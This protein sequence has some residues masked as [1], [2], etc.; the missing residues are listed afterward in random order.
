MSVSHCAEAG[1]FVNE[2][3]PA[4]VTVTEGQRAEFNCDALT[5]NAIP[6]FLPVQFFTV[7]VLVTS[8][9]SSD[10]VQ[11][12]NCSFSRAELMKCHHE[13]Q[14]CSGL[15]VSNSSIGPPHVLN[16]RL[17][18]VWSEAELNLT[19]SEVVCAV[20]VGG[21]TQWAHTATLTVLPA[22]PLPEGTPK[23]LR[24]LVWGGLAGSVAVMV[25]CG[26]VCLLSLA[27]WYRRKQQTMPLQLDQCML[28][29]YGGRGQGHVLL[30]VQVHWPGRRSPPAVHPRPPLPLA[31]PRWSPSSRSAYLREG[32]AQD[33]TD[34]YWEWSNTEI[35]WTQGSMLTARQ[36]T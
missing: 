18:A 33:G 20:A 22:S 35:V 25:V 3:L 16:H 4:E 28:H 13:D 24:Q 5:T 29:V 9:P 30:C 14:N 27:L 36:E 1:L 10:P 23:P 21:I 7:A 15:Q 31:W 26:G 8:P 32:W 12:F 2:T 34:M 17:T 19:G 11:C 6:G